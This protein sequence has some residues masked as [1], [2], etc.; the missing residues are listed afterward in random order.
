MVLNIL[1][2][3]KNHLYILKRLL[4]WWKNV[5]GNKRNFRNWCDFD[6]VELL[7]YYEL[8]LSKKKKN[9]YEFCLPQQHFLFI[10]IVNTILKYNDVI[11]IQS[12]RLSTIKLE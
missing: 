9:Y 12:K 5:W 4:H 6:D 11:E 1:F 3:F 8:Y 7:I 10:I 2:L